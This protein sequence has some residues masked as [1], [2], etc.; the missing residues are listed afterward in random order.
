[1]YLCLYVCMHSCVC[2]NILH[3]PEWQRSV[4]NKRLRRPTR[5]PLQLACCMR[6]R[7]HE[8]CLYRVARDCK[9]H[10]ARQR[11]QRLIWLDVRKRNREARPSGGA[12]QRR[13]RREGARSEKS[14]AALA[15]LTE[16]G[17]PAPN[18]GGRRPSLTY[19]VV[20]D[21]S[22]RGQARGNPVTRI[23]F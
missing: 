14:G 10:N 19:L 17:Q 3:F 5:H 21:E 2:I 13:R 18:A 7:H 4:I 23:Q 8:I 16:R 15:G 22:R 12:R 11:H 20:E 6:F 9:R 1:M